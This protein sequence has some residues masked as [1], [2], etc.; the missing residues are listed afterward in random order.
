MSEPPSPLW[1]KLAK[2]IPPQSFT[3]DEIRT[4]IYAL[5][6]YRQAR[7]AGTCGRP[8]WPEEERDILTL[9]CRLGLALRHADPRF[10]P[11]GLELKDERSEHDGDRDPWQRQP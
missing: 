4:L 7:R 9:S 5:F 2:D 11:P 10:D 1:V 3:A 8:E 6:V